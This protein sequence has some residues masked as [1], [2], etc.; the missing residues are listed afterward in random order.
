MVI[1]Q[2]ITKYLKSRTNNKLGNIKYADIENFNINEY[3]NYIN[4]NTKLFEK[5]HLL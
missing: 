3:N 5:Y 4:E 1:N 2:E